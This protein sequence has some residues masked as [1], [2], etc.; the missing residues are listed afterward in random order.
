MASTTQSTQTT[1]TVSLSLS[2][3]S[4]ANHPTQ[5]PAQPPAPIDVYS[6]EAPAGIEQPYL[7]RMVPLHNQTAAEGVKDEVAMRS[8]GSYGAGWSM[9]QGPPSLF[10]GMSCLLVVFRRAWAEELFSW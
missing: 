3:T 10:T 8:V 9:V 1:Q 2:L 6:L 5:A 4:S 7:S